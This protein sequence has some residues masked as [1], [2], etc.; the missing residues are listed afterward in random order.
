MVIEI[1]SITTTINITIITIL[2]ISIFCFQSDLLPHKGL[3]NINFG[4]LHDNKFSYTR[5]SSLFFSSILKSSALLSL[6]PLFLNINFDTPET[7]VS[8]AEWLPNNAHLISIELRFD[9][10]F[11][12]FFSVALFVS[13][14]ILE[15][16]HYYMAQ[17]P[18]PGNFFRLLIIF[19][20]NMII[21]TSTNNVFLLFIGWEGVGFLSFLLISWWTTRASANNSALQAVIY[22][23]IGDIGILL[24]FSLSVTTFNS[25]TLSEIFVLQPTNSLGNILLVW[26]LIAAAGKSAQFGLHPWLPAAME[27]PTPL[28]ALL[29]SSTMVVAGI[30]LLIR[31]GPAYS[32]ISAFNTWCLILGFITAILAATTAISQHDIKKIVAYSTTSQLGLMM[33][34]IGLNQPEIA[35]FHV[36]THAFFKA[37]LF[38]SSGSIIHSLKDEQDI[39]K[40]GGLYLILPNTT[41]CIIL[42]SLALSGTPFLAGFYSKD[43][44]LELGL[45]SL[46]N[47]TGIILALLATLLTAA[48]SFRI[49]HFCFIGNP[50]FSPLS[51][52][53]EE[54]TNLTNAL[55]RLA[56]G[57]I[58][59]GWVI[60]NFILQ[61]PNI[62]VSLALKSLATLLT[63]SGII[64]TI[65]LLHT[66]SLNMPPQ[67]LINTNTFTT[68]QWFYEHTSH[69]ILTTLSFSL[70][71]T[72]ST[73]SIDRGW[74][75]NLGAQGI[76]LASSEI[77]QNYQLAQTGYIKQ[78]LLL[79]MSTFT[80]IAIISAAL[81]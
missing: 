12:L 34:A 49:I 21:L 29:H 27:G 16:S 80:V 52:T 78:Y 47:L 46:S 15:F 17:D 19:L 75:E 31:R 43:L 77:S 2:L 5:N 24:F 61:P 65:S 23:R 7:I 3:P 20:L 13:W 14:S 54:N 73:Q 63:V 72:G 59:S 8:I 22:N 60:S 18:A 32:D 35:L 45:S 10:S 69:T 25:W 30:F 36:C 6:I 11:N 39:R 9:L 66:L 58:I 70:S 64:L 71:L 50:T 56:A 1:T 26:A 55:N 4:T 44:I 57:T 67:N 28:S 74:S 37:M 42:G 48:Y 41:A 40:M 81:L 51:P 33:V 38:L 76:N 53:S 68:N 62:T 79:S